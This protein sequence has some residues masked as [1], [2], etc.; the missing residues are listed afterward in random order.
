MSEIKPFCFWGCSEIRESL[1]L[2]VDSERQLLDRLET[3]PAESIYHHTVRCLLR[4]P[5]VS[6]VYPDDFSSWVA[7]ELGDVALA[8]KLALPSPFD[9]PDTDAFRQ[10]LL[11]VLDDH[12]GELRFDPHVLL[13]APFYFERGHLSVVPLDLEAHDL[14]SFRSALAQVDDSSIYYHSVEAIGRLDK[15][16]GDMAAWV[17]EVLDLGDLARALEGID[18]FV[19]SLSAVRERMLE[20]V[21][22]A[23]PWGGG[24]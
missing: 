4:R 22:A 20:L 24:A 7:A 16:R 15:Q 10:H 21:D 19:M 3:V 6:T 8:E 13:G 18:P 12:L 14:R 1:N 5:V 17:D 23:S 11:D 9:F 2:R